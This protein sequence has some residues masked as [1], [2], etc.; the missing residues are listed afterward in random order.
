MSFKPTRCPSWP[1][2]YPL[3]LEALKSILTS[4]GECGSWHR[5]QDRKGFIRRYLCFPRRDAVRV[6]RPI[7]VELSVILHHHLPSGLVHL[8]LPACDYE[9]GLGRE[10]NPIVVCVS[11]QRLTDVANQG[12][13]D[14]IGQR[15]DWSG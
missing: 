10:D 14:V 2:A 8:C 12:R 9:I 1:L 13:P 15:S 4:A 5:L 7:V 6:P 11:A 3:S